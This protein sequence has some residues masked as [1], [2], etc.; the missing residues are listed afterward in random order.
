MKLDGVLATGIVTT[1]IVAYDTQALGEP[2]KNDGM[3]G[4]GLVFGFSILM[5]GLMGLT[6]Y[7]EC[8]GMLPFYTLENQ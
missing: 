1:G 7:A 3:M 5:S 6:E 8:K 4:A 2:G